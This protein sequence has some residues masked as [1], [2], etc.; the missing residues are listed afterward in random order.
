MITLTDIEKI[1]PSLKENWINP[2]PDGRMRWGGRDE[3]DTWQSVFLERE[4]QMGLLEI[5]NGL[6]NVSDM[7]VLDLGCEAGL[8]SV[9]LSQKFKKV[10]AIDSDKTSITNAK[11]TLAIFDSFGF[12]VSNIELIHCRF[13][14]D[15]GGKFKTL[16]PNK[17]EILLE[18]DAMFLVDSV[19]TNDNL[20][21][22]EEYN[23]V[24]SKVK[25]I[26]RTDREN[27]ETPIEQQEEYIEKARK[28]YQ[29]NNFNLTEFKTMIHCRRAD[30]FIGRNDNI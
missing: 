25:M 19:G 1:I 10:I 2:G 8:W 16:E 5:I 29:E 17:K 30:V 9:I 14:T 24:L 6:E 28:K 11:K 4:T 18:Y 15:D 21:F 27:F 13:Q 20:Q 23:D 26:I 7:T 12:D 22:F 3:R